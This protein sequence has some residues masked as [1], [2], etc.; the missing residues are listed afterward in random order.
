MYVSP[1]QEF[2]YVHI[3][4]SLFIWLKRVNELTP[5]HGF[6]IPFNLY[7]DDLDLQQAFG[8]L[9]TGAESYVP[10]IWPNGYIL[11]Y[12]ICD[13]LPFLW[14]RRVPIKQL[15]LKLG[16]IIPFHLHIHDLNLQPAFGTLTMGADTDVPLIW[17]NG[18]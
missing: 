8:T 18:L 11:W 10:L 2:C 17:T 14:L 12:S 5:K 7:I 9:T 4:L 15:T 13:W 1:I 6:T 16:F 3:T